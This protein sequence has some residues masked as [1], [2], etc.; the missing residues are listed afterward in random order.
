M[1]S[2]KCFN[3]FS[4]I[5]ANNAARKNKYNRQLAT[6]F[7]DTL[8]DDK[9]FPIFMTIPHEHAGGV[10]VA[11]HMRCWVAFDEKGTKAFIDVPMDLYDALVTFQVPDETKAN[12]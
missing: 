3:L 11:L 1:E 12:V 5:E 7:I 4:L 8:P 9:W 10:K 6:K 2:Y